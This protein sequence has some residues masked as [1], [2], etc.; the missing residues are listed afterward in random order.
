MLLREIVPLIILSRS[1]FTFLLEG[2]KAK[3]E[4]TSAR[5]IC[6]MT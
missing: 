6:A 4:A 1:Y 3:S 2:L 5:N